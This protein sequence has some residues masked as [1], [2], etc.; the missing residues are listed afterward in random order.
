M[1]LSHHGVVLMLKPRWWLWHWRS[2]AIDASFNAYRAL[3]L[4]ITIDASAL[5]GTTSIASLALF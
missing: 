4:S 3:L 5:L 2:L 1:E